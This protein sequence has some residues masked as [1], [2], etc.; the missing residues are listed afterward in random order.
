MYFIVN[1]LGVVVFLALGVLFSKKRKEI[2]WRSVGS[3]LVLNVFLAWF[4]TSF[5]VGREIIVAA[6]A[7]FSWLTPS[8]LLGLGAGSGAL[9]L[10]WAACEGTHTVSPSPRVM[11][12]LPP[13][14]RS[15]QLPLPAWFMLMCR[16]SRSMVR[17]RCT[18]SPRPL[19]K[20]F[21]S[22]KKIASG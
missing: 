9:A 21:R 2:Q 22:Q 7:A 16:W 8:T 14:W 10:V 4:L 17:R 12:A 15:V 3:L 18:R 6:A 19:P 13:R 5:S 20:I 1:V 11:K